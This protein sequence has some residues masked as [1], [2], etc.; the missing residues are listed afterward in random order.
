MPVVVSDSTV[1]GWGD[2]RIVQPEGRQVP[3][4]QNL[5]VPHGNPSAAGIVVST[6]AD[7]PEVQVV[8]PALQTLSDGTQ[9]AFAVQE[10]QAP[11]SQTEFS[12]QPSPLSAF[13]CWSTQ[14]CSPVLQAKAP[15]WQGADVGMQTPPAV[16]PTQLPPLQTASVPQ[17]MPFAIV[18]S[19]SRHTGDP[20]EQSV[21]PVWHA[22]AGTHGEPCG[23]LT[24]APELQTSSMPQ[25][26]PFGWLP[27]LS[28][29]TE[30]P[31]RQEVT[32]VWQ[33]ASDGM[34]ATPSAQLAQAPVRHTLSMP[35]VVPSGAF[36]EATQIA[37]P[38]SQAIL[39]VAQ[40]SPAG[41]QLAPARQATQAPLSQT[42]PLPQVTPL[43]TD[44]WLSSQR[45]EPV[46]QS[47]VPV[48]QVLVGVQAWPW[49]QLAQ[50]PLLQTCWSP[51]VMPFG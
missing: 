29:Q 23:Q 16:H 25:A 31:V 14:I 50:E 33:G 44:P 40:A 48:W 5:P 9:V 41:V 8:T 49:A 7:T 28:R 11:S 1:A 21:L 35:Q 51:Q 34:Q 26:S 36:P 37:E 22:F 38:V 32:P 47:M 27:W 46:E 45:G 6:Q 39:P 24:Q 15:T 17:V 19:V 20:V 2:A 4:W 12:P 13:V 30:A 10:T 3:A 43:L 42:I 18:P